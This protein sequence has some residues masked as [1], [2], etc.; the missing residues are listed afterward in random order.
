MLLGLADSD[1]F[2]YYMKDA[3]YLTIRITKKKAHPNPSG[4]LDMKSLEI[5]C[6][7]YSGALQL[8]AQCALEAV[9]E[10]KSLRL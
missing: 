1:L 5:C 4:N 10:A 8:F 7:L 9:V 3:Q 2:R 6:K